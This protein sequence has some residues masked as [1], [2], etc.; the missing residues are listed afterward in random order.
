M[1]LETPS[2]A[3]CTSAGGKRRAKV[4]IARTPSLTPNPTSLYICVSARQS[5]TPRRCRDAAA[6]PGFLN[7][8]L[9]ETIVCLEKLLRP[10]RQPST[11]QVLV[12]FFGPFVLAESSCLTFKSVELPLN[13]APAS[14]LWFR[15]IVPCHVS[16]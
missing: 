9:R 10:V 5:I 16:A 14:A 13:P 1:S 7:P 3:P 12:S 8:F 2:N 4:G 15:T 6:K 11:A